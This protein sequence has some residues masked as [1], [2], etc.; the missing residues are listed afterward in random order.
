MITPLIQDIKLFSSVDIITFSI[1]SL[2]TAGSITCG[3]IWTTY[4]CNNFIM[5]TKYDCN[6]DQNEDLI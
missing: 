1:L 4:D 2:V 3:D 5:W 6:G